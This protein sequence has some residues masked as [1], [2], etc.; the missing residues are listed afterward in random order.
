MPFS[1]EVASQQLTTIDIYLRVKVAASHNPALHIIAEV[2]RPCRNQNS[3]SG[4]N[5]AER[6]S[7]V[8]DPTRI[9]TFFTT[10]SIALGHATTTG[11]NLAAPASVPSGPIRPNRS[12]F[13]PPRRSAAT[14][15]VRPRHC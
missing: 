5:H 6:A 12:A 8:S 3:R 11:T 1:T 13:A 2:D 10:R 9:I 14:T 15:A 4:R 7:D